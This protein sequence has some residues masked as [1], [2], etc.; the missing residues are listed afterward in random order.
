MPRLDDPHGRKRA[1]TRADAGATDADVDRELAF[2]RK[3]IAR[4]QLTLVDQAADV[5]N[6]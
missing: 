1:Q 5:C 4:L 6:H 2:S 3:A